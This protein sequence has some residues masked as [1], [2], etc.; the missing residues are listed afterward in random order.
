MSD[1]VED[2]TELTTQTTNTLSFNDL[3]NIYYN[4]NK[5]NLIES[6]NVQNV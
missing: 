5:K 4:N 2:I 6:F 3:F 1:I